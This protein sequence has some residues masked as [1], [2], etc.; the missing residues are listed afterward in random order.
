M[1][2]H[3]LEYDAFEDR[4]RESRA[5]RAKYPNRVPII[6]HAK[7]DDDPSID[8]NKYMCSQ[9]LSWSRLFYVIR[10]RLQM[11]ASTALFFFTQ[12]TN[13]LIVGTSMVGDVYARHAHEDGFLYVQYSAE[14]AFG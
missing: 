2:A 1:Y 14:N 7:R 4:C 9:T 13:T 5:M 11:D 10:K 3:K 12:D 8:K 6:V